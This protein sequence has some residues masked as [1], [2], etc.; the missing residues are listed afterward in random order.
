[1]RHAILKVVIKNSIWGPGLLEKY[2][3]T[4]QIYSGETCGGQEK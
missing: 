4:V 3:A 1:M 2:P